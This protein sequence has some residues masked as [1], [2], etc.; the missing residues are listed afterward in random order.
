MPKEAELTILRDL[1]DKQREVF[2]KDPEAA[3]KLLA[4]GEA[5][6][7]SSIQPVELASWT[8][9]ASTILNLD[10]VVTKN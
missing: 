5:P 9:V 3:R 1:L 8:V 4:N 10:E 7:D 6:A 2:G